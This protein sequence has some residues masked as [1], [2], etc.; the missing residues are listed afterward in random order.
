[1]A[2]GAVKLSALHFRPVDYFASHIFEISRENC[3]ISIKNFTSS[4]SFKLNLF[5]AWC[6]ILQVLHSWYEP[7]LAA[8]CHPANNAWVG[9]RFGPL[10]NLDCR[11][12]LSSEK[13]CWSSLTIHYFYETR[14]SLIYAR[15]VCLSNLLQKKDHSVTYEMSCQ[16][17]YFL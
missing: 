6:A 15:N 4:C 16:L 2:H 1:M 8:L 10:Q 11:M 9:F 13:T 3:I 12:N 14:A 17:S 7:L 5:Q